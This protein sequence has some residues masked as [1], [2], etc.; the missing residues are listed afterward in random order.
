MTPQ[1]SLPFRVN[2]SSV[3]LLSLSQ[4]SEAS[5]T[6]SIANSTSSVLSSG[7]L[8]KNAPKD[9]NAYALN[10]WLAQQK[11]DESTRYYGN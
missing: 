2:T 9:D 11:Q 10:L 6:N 4:A 7:N 3:S 1:K 8:S 5:N